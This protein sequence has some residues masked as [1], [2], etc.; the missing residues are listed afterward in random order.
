MRRMVPISDLAASVDSLSKMVDLGKKISKI[1]VLGD[2]VIPADDLKAE[3]LSSIL[4]WFET[5]NV[6]LIAAHLDHCEIVLDFE[7]NS[8][9]IEGSKREGSKEWI[10]RFNHQII[11]GQ[12]SSSISLVEHENCSDCEHYNKD[13]NQFDSR[14]RDRH[15]YVG[16][17]EPMY[18]IGEKGGF[19]YWKFVRNE[20]INPLNSF[21]FVIP[22]YS[23]EDIGLLQRINLF[24]CE[25]AFEEGIPIIHG[26]TGLFVRDATID[27]NRKIQ[28]NVISEK[29]RRTGFSCPKFRRRQ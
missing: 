22:R 26:S 13:A 20:S 14:F 10:Y 8:I 6:N 4:L 16:F 2:I 19:G 15:S 17:L 29:P 28:C 27:K 12:D 23:R 11:N 7:D 3:L 24:G 1:N 9:C 18:D 21:N 5:H 25:F